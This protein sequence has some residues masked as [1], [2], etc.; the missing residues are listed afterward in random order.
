MMKFTIAVGVFTWAYSFLILSIHGMEFVQNS[1][2]IC[3][4]CW[5]H[6]GCDLTPESFV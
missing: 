2:S 6:I 3:P 1:M 4:W 5:E